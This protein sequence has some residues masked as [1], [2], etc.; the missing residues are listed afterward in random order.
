MSNLIAI[1]GP[2]KGRTFPLREATVLG[3]SIE[4]DLRLDD[5]AISRR[6]ARISL[7]GGSWFIEDLGSGNGTTVNG[8]AIA[9]PT[10][11][12]NGDRIGLAENVFRFAAESEL[13][14]ESGVT[15]VDVPSAAAP[16]A[17]ETLDVKASSMEAAMAQRATAPDALIKVQQRFGAVLEISNAVRIQLD[18]DQLLNQMMD[19]LF[20]VFPQA[21]RG[22]IMLKADESEELVLRAA[23]QRG[24]EQPEAV[25]LSRHIVQKAMGDGVALLSDDAMGDQRFAM[26]QSVMNF[27]IRSMM[28]V[29]IIVNDEALGIIHLDTTRQDRQFTRDDL[30]LLVWVTSQTAFA[31]ANAALHRKLLLQERTERDL[32]LARQVQQSL[33]PRHLPEV[34]GMQFRAWYK[35]AL[36]IGGDFYDFVPLKNGQ[37][38]IV[39]AD[40]SG[41]GIPA[42][43]VMARMSSAIREL[44]LTEDEP[45]RVVALADDRLEA[46][47]AEGTFITLIF[48]LLDPRSRT[49]QMV[50]AGHPSPLLRKG[51]T[52]QV[53]EIKTCTNFAVGFVPG[54]EFEA[55]SFRIE[56]GD[57]IC[58]YSD[59]ITEA[60]N[61]QQD[62]YGSDRLKSVAAL[63]AA[64]AE[65]LMENI[66]RDVHAFV[67]SAHQS[68][69][70][71]LVCFGAT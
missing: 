14:R 8:K 41:K 26:A 57:F 13:P 12:K 53:S 24:R 7:A 68:D 52:G 61:A 38:A 39:V 60:M 25:T 33:L 50:N 49:L 70:M 66:L 10:P 17:R 54:A 62:C 20:G 29:P 30:E 37:L 59:G 51:S 71:T 56:P 46:M 35:A 32:Y 23:R 19:R 48:A 11:L 18:M 22:F 36:E 3:R 9:A 28:C 47:E 31:I 1:E 65:Q 40:V 43:L 15:I 6:H 16:L 27:R 2:F 55:E 63:P 58:F 45:R 44:A 69:D 5:L 4:A 67:G 42:A 21:D 64:S 34:A